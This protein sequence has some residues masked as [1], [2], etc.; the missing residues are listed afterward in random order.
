LA[1]AALPPPLEDAGAAVDVDVD[2][3]AGAAL[4]AELL[5]LLLLLLPHAAT[6]TTQASVS[7]PSSGFLQVSIRLLLVCNPGLRPLSIGKN[8]RSAG[9]P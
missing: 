5:L 4:E 1:T 2:D 6:V 8:A 3:V 7:A 9:A